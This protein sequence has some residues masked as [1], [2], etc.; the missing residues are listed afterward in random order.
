MVLDAASILGTATPDIE[1]GEDRDLLADAALISAILEAANITRQPR[2]NR[3][4][5]RA[6]DKLVKKFTKEARRVAFAL[7]EGALSLTAFEAEMLRLIRANHTAAASIFAEGAANLTSSEIAAT[8]GQIRSESAFMRNFT[9]QIRQ[10]VRTATGGRIVGRAGM[11]GQAPRNTYYDVVATNQVDGGAREVRNIL[12]AVDNCETSTVPGC[13]EMTA[14]GWVPVD[15]PGFVLPG[16]RTCISNC[17]CFLEFR[18]GVAGEG[19][20]F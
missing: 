20:R 6:I 10:G 11:Y 9:R 14:L 1:P 12:S 8:A 19:E 5:R 16:N 7:N 3:T 18:G 15:D 17:Q 13:I 2:L 4:K